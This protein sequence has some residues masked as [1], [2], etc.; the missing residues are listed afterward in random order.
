M[1]FNSAKVLLIAFAILFKILS[2]YCDS[3]MID[4]SETFYSFKI[5]PNFCWLSQRIFALTLCKSSSSKMSVP[6]WDRNFFIF[7]T[8]TSSLYIVCYF[9]VWNF[10]TV[11]TKLDSFH[12]VNHGIPI[13]SFKPRGLKFRNRENNE[14]VNP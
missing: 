4:T 9:S 6:T 5:L 2:T 12:E 10:K 7:L 14:F 3:F 13:I 8:E 11:L 1:H